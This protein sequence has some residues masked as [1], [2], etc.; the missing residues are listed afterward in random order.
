[1]TNP[2]SNAPASPFGQGQQQQASVPSG[3]NVIINMMSSRQH[4]RI[5]ANIYGNQSNT[6]RNVGIAP[7]TL[8]MVPP[9][10]HLVNNTNFVANNSTNAINNINSN[11]GNVNNKANSTISTDNGNGSCHNGNYMP[12]NVANAISSN[13][14][15]Q[16]QVHIA[17]LNGLNFTLNEALHPTSYN[18]PATVVAPTPLN[19]M[20]GTI[21][22]ITLSSLNGTVPEFLYQLTKMLTDEGNKEV[23]VWNPC[24]TFGNHKIGG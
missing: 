13:M 9:Q 1:M 20:H 6:N 18:A 11:I 21:D 7:S 12:V 3:N 8:T 5:T 14:I 24:V 22:A 16:Q 19:N 15:A 23:I 10:Q 2:D 17:G 4:S